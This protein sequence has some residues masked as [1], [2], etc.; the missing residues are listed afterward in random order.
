[1]IAETPPDPAEV[2]PPLHSRQRIATNFVGVA[3]SSAI[4]MVAGLFISI[5]VRRTLGPVAYGEVSW[6]AAVLA[7]LALIPSS[8]LQLI[9]QREVARRLGDTERLASVILTLQGLLCLAAY[10]LILVIAAL[11]LRG[12]EVS[13]LLLL[14]GIAL[15]FTSLDVGWILQGQERMVAPAVATLI[16]NLAQFPA[17]LAFVHGPEDVIVFA[18]INLPFAAANLGYRFWYLHRHG[19]LD[20]AQLRLRLAG[21]RRILDES[22]PLAVSQGAIV[23]LYNCDAIILGFTNGDDT[24]GQYVSA[25]KL[26]LVATVISGALC[27]AYFP[28]LARVHDD[29]PQAKRVQDEFLSLMV[30]MGLPIA[31]LGW[32]VGRHVVDIMYGRAFFESG[33]YFEWLCLNV[34]L[35]FLNLGLGAPLTAWGMQKLHFKITGSAALVNLVL[36][37]ALIPLY[38][39]W[40]AIA[41]TLGSEL[42]VFAML[43]V[44]RRRIGLGWVPLGRV[45]MPAAACSMAIA[46][47][48]VMLPRSLDAYWWLQCLGGTILLGAALFIFERR[49]VNSVFKLFSAAIS[50]S[51]GIA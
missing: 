11:N 18:A 21:A 15:F 14:Q 12:P 46:F 7:Y 51:G 8:G 49:I 44:M 32:A 10:A 29:P 2:T 5:Y 17:L 45:L 20:L 1:M 30:W 31:A 36:N 19:F 27:N 35:I 26:M 23:I 41:T 42:M 6:N 9:G 33:L 3:L 40:A 16:F 25:Y 50:R 48:I 37:L 13:Q 38:G 47:G 39:P 34:G 24:V 43:I 22:W 28:A 4:N